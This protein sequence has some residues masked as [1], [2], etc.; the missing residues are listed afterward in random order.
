MTV[1]NKIV[2]LMYEDGYVNRDVDITEHSKLV[3][4]FQFDSLD[5][6]DVCAMIENHYDIYFG[7]VD[8]GE[9]ETVGD[10]V[11]LVEKHI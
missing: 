11:K 7:E 1:L 2:E 8:I 9:L 4:D 5:K 10:I 6:M 3:N